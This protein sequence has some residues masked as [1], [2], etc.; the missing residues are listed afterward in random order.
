MKQI[1]ILALVMLLPQF[2]SAQTDKKVNA[3]REK[4]AHAQSV[5]KYKDTDEWMEHGAHFLTMKSQVNYA[6]AGN[7]G[8]DIEVIL[9][10]GN[11][12]S[13]DFNRVKPLLVRQ[14]TTRSTKVYREMLF[15]EDTSRLIFCYQRVGTDGYDI[16][17]LRYYFDNGK[18]IMSSP[19][20]TGSSYTLSPS[21]VLK[22][23]DA[24]K[25]MIKNYN[26]FA[27]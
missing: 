15:D 4:Y 14:S 22:S 19:K 12:E 27:N 26:D 7:V 17:E 2:A 25:Q 18:L 6:G 3:I 20:Y 9:T 21:Q 11:Y 16:E 24:L 8:E 10:L 13:D 23:A 1:F 5:A